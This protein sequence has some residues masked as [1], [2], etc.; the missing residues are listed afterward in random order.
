MAPRIY[1][2]RMILTVHDELV[3][4]GPEADMGTSKKP[5]VLP[6]LLVRSME[7]SYDQIEMKLKEWDGL[8][9]HWVKKKIRLKDLQN[10]VD[11]I[12]SDRWSKK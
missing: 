3:I 6:Q 8:D 5:G 7:W 11:V 9:N 1:D 12:V 10:K 2:G 4:Q